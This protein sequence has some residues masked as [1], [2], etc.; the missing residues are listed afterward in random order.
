M[1]ENNITNL[2]F[3]CDGV[4]LDSNSIKTKAFQACLFN[5]NKN[6]VSEF[7]KYHKDNQGIDRFKKL[8]FFFKD[9]KKNYNDIDYNKALKKYSDLCDSNLKKSKLVDGIEEFLKLA[10]EKN[11]TCYVVSGSEQNELRR[12]LEYK[13]LSKYF[14]GIYG[15]PLSKIENIDKI[16]K[17]N[18]ILGK[19]FFF[20]DSEA[21]L[22]AS[23]KFK[24]EFIYISQYSDW[25]NG[26]E[27]CQKNNYKVFKNF[28]DISSKFNFR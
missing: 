20:G 14:K 24:F 26:I 23:K 19:N 10:K 9:L 7:I 17:Y 21:D 8:K 25:I 15:S 2:F 5:E 22:N 6:L 13:K 16:S 27:Y 11:Y 1:Q 3:D 28:I 12:V 18:S 4:I